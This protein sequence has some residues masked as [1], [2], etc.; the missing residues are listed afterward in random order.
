MERDDAR[1]H[2]GAAAGLDQAS[3]TVS[4][5][6][7]WRVFRETWG[8]E[9]APPE[10]EERCREVPR[11]I[12]RKVH[13]TSALRHQHQDEPDK[14]ER[15]ENFMQCMQRQVKQQTQ[16]GSGSHGNQNMATISRADAMQ[17]KLT[18]RSGSSNPSLVGHCTHSVLRRNVESNGIM[19]RAITMGQTADGDCSGNKRKPRQTLSSHEFTLTRSRPA[20]P[21]QGALAEENRLQDIMLR[22]MLA[23]ENAERQGEEVVPPPPARDFLEELIE[24]KL[25][26]ANQQTIIDTFSTPVRRSSQKRPELW[27]QG[28]QDEAA[29]EIRALRDEVRELREERRRER[30][31]RAKET[32]ELRARIDALARKNGRCSCEND[33]LRSQ[34][35]QLTEQLSREA[36]RTT[37]DAGAA[38]QEEDATVLKNLAQNLTREIE[39]LQDAN[40]G[41]REENL[42]C[43][44]ELELIRNAATRGAQPSGMK[45]AR[46]V[47][48]IV[49]SRRLK[50][51]SNLGSSVNS[52]SSVILTN[53]NEEFEVGPTPSL[54]KPLPRTSSFGWY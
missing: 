35:H 36:G 11:G 26:V 19:S 43:R 21:A 49:A 29:D 18:G 27:P 10:M 20:A 37:S 14:S 31:A 50:S 52:Q 47:S 1:R 44:R 54:A 32:A 6:P 30:V 39:R 4:A 40:E 51:R 9:V 16:G 17:L 41:L 28:P 8:K 12:G 3:Q 46:S 15:M 2:A 25:K 42:R 38:S 23:L 34:N 7:G 33:A 24:L 13:S 22:K 5:S 53:R 48:S 45:K